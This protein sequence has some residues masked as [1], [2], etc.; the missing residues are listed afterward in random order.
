MVRQERF[1]KILGA[2]LAIGTHLV[3][4]VFGV[5]SGIKYIY[6]PPQEQSFLIDFSEKEETVKVEPK[7]GSEARSEL[8]NPTK[9]V[10]LV[11]KSEAQRVGTKANL[12]EE[13]T[14]DD[15][16][17]V[18]KYEP[19]REKPIDKR[20]LFHAANNKAAKDTLAEQTAARVSDALKAGHAQGN[21]SS[22]KQNGEPSAKLKGRST[23]SLP[24]P[25]YK[26][27]E[28]GIVV[29]AVWVDQ[30]GNVKQARAGAEGTT[31]HSSELLQAARKAAMES[32]FNQSADAPSL[33]EGTI[34][35]VF[36][37]R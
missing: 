34:T 10:E 5:F 12:A 27:Q 31:V 36:N 22:G 7:K 14:V 6:P 23:L 19:P 24:K 20:A 1:G 11:Q 8:V 26:V 35:Y 16:G 9:P 37:L 15:F 32:H 4:L 33:Q 13:A 30:Y 21:T 3:L 25:A 28:A 18:E 2:V 17:D 29:V